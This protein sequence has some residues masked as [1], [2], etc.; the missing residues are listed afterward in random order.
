M[1]FPSERDRRGKSGTRKG[2]D[3]EDPEL[4]LWGLGDV[5]GGFPWDGGTCM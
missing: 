1:D 4:V 2:G 5:C 3:E